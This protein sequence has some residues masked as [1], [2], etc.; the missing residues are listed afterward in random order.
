MLTL[1][2]TGNAASQCV[3]KQLQFHCSCTC[4]SFPC[5]WDWQNEEYHC[6]SQDMLWAP[7]WVYILI[8]KLWPCKF[9]ECFVVTFSIAAPCPWSFSPLY[10]VP[11][12]P[13]AQ[14]WESE[15]TWYQR[16]VVP[17]LCCGMLFI[18]PIRWQGNHCF[19]LNVQSLYTIRVMCL[20]MTKSVP[21]ARWLQRLRSRSTKNLQLHWHSWITTGDRALDN[22]SCWLLG[23]VL[24][25]WTKLSP[26]LV[27]SSLLPWIT[28]KM[29]RQQRT[30]LCLLISTWAFVGFLCGLH[31]LLTHF[32]ESYQMDVHYST[33]QSH[34]NSH[35]MVHVSAP[36]RMLPSNLLITIFLN[37]SPFML[38]VV[39]SLHVHF[40][41]WLLLHLHSFNCLALFLAAINDCGAMHL[42]AMQQ[43][44]SKPRWN[45]MKG[46]VC[47]I[48]TIGQWDR[49]SQKHKKTENNCG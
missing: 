20:S 18:F 19:S 10:W 30:S 21:M 39:A 5:L 12:Y 9:R 40:I 25:H 46:R 2:W 41:P 7:G 35:S 42:W 43:A 11:W 36:F 44:I 27:P 33:L 4:G 31:S 24:L 23:A 47:I 22:I 48:T 34:I 8:W 29:T 15:G 49:K 32:T 1:P 28:W 14:H 16:S 3:A 37:C 13:E 6:Y 45:C 17:L 26:C 38:L